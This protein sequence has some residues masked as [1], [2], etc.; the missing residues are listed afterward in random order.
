MIMFK[1]PIINLKTESKELPISLEEVKNFLKV[2]FE[3]DDELIAKLIKT[4]TNQ[5]ETYID[6]TLILKTYI[7]SIYGLKEESVF[8]P[9]PPVISVD[10][11]EVVKTSITRE[12]EEFTDYCFDSVGGIVNFKNKPASFYRIDIT[13]TACVDSINDELIQGILIHIARMYEDRSGY[14]P[15]PLNTANIYKKYKQVKL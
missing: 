10:K 7:Y 3:D 13:Y 9:Y 4:A 12:K 1:T 2:D 6:K 15:M 11:V 8:L 5:C 14:S